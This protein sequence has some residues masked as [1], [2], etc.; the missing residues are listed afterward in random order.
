M[1]SI[2]SKTPRITARSKIFE[3]FKDCLIKIS[4]NLQRPHLPW[5]SLPPWNKMLLN[6][7]SSKIVNISMSMIR[8]FTLNTSFR[9]TG[10]AHVCLMPLHNS[11][12]HVYSDLN[13]RLDFAKAVKP[14]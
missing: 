8:S 6:V 4:E 3:Y 14:A 10:E 11:R 2:V 1:D 12:G 7:V 13:E 5:N 9:L